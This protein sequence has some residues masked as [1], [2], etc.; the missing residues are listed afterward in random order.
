MT[1]G[2]ADIDFMLWLL[3]DPTWL[4]FIG[5]RNV[6]TKE[7]AQ[8]YISAGPVDM[9]NRLG[10]GQCIVESRE[11]GTALG[12]CGL[13][14]RNYLDHPDIGFAFLPAYW[15]LGYAFEAAS[16]SLDYASRE[17]GVPRI[18]ATCRP[19]NVPSQALL[20]KLGLRFERTFRHPDGDR[21]LHLYATQ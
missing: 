7:D 17:L 13:S 8:Q 10:Y 19:D 1:T 2:A 21:D 4:R 5:D 6:R 15:R 16:A 20:R 14:Q 11:T 18:V 9:Y 12:I 3:N